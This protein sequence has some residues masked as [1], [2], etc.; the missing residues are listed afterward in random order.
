MKLLKLTAKTFVRIA[1]IILEPPFSCEKF[2]KVKTLEDIK[3][4]SGNS[5]LIFDYCNSSLELYNFCKINSIPYGVK[6]ISIKELIFVANLNAKY[7]FCDTIEKAKKFQ[8]IAN[9]YLMDT[10][11]ILLISN[12]DDIENIADFGIDGIK[13]RRINEKT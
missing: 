7:I 2:T 4:S 1:M 6:I 11:I 9:D 12:L 3:N 5:T 10:K 13:L 8:K